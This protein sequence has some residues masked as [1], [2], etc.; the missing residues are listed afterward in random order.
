M[1]RRLHNFDIAEVDYKNGTIINFRPGKNL[2][3]LS[4]W[5]L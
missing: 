3:S 1:K 4:K 5:I 2:F